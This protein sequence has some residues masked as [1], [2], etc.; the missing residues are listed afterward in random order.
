MSGLLIQE[1][2]DASL[3]Q[4]A[5]STRKKATRGQIWSPKITNVNGND[6][7][8]NEYKSETLFWRGYGARGHVYHGVRFL[9]ETYCTND[10]TRFPFDVND[11][12]FKFGTCK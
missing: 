6:L 9:I 5:F 8:R 3:S 10:L 7:L 4:D 11:C 2:Y 1:W 12:T